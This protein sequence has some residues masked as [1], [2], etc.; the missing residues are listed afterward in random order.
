MALGAVSGD[1]VRM[2]LQE[3]LLLALS[4]IAIGLPVALWLTRLTRSFLL[5]TNHLT[6]MTP[7]V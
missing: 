3:T 1:V 4:G 2:V 7:V 5:A 6:H